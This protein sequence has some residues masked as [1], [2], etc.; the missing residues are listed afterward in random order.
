[1]TTHDVWF[2]YFL[3]DVLYFLLYVAI[4]N[5]NQYIYLVKSIDFSSE[6]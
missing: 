6:Q 1:M 2:G 4:D 3:L 5:I